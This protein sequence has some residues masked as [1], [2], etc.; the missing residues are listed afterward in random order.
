MEILAVGIG[1]AIGAMLRFLV[2]EIIVYETGFPLATLAANLIGCFLLSFLLSGGLLQ[3]RPHMK[4]A[5]TTGL[6]GSFTTFS[7]FSYETVKLVDNGLFGLAFLY[8]GLSVLGGLGCSLIGFKLANGG[9][10]S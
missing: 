10:K 1:G 7:T 6:L 8:I 5:L 4:V 2:G 3:H 9:G